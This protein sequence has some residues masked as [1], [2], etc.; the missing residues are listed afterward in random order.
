[1]KN[2]SFDILIDFAISENIFIVE[3]KPA[4]QKEESLRCV[5]AAKIHDCPFVSPLQNQVLPEP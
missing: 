3:K 4:A 2:M 1:M 5:H